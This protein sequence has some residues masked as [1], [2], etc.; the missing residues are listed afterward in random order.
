MRFRLIV[1]VAAAGACAHAMGGSRLTAQDAPAE[2][3]GCLDVTVGPWVVDT[4]VDRLHPRDRHEWHRIPP[5][6]RFGGPDDR[7]PSLTRI[8]VPEDDPDA[9][10]IRFAGAELD[11]D[12]LRMHL[13]DGFTGVRA[14]LGRS[15]DGWTGTA[16]TVSDALPYQ[17]SARPVAMSRVDC[18]SPLPIPG[19]E[20]H[21]LG[22][23]VELEGGQAIT[24]GEPLPEQLETATLPPFDWNWFWP[25]VFA[26]LELTTPRNAVS[27]V[28]RTRGFFGATD[29][30]QVHTDPDGLVYSV[31]LLY[32]DPG[33]PETLE[34]RLLGRYG[35]P[36][37]ASGVP[38][39]HI[40]RSP[41]T[42]LWLRPS[43][44]AQAEVLL[45]DRGR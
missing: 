29:S 23:V 31:R 24:L 26:E 15:G 42:S 7:R 1:T 2:L 41:T 17:M 32:V 19:D 27:V 18:E 30:I 6:I 34:E 20:S 3:S 14:T 22:R 12:S 10:H 11:G 43:W 5:R 36:G 37:T 21:P 33:T 28:G 25:T 9:P 13:T 38:G 45:S 40:Y 35:A 39:V 44:A 8:V 16:R 4:Y